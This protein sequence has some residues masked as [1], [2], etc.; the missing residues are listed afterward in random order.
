MRSSFPL[1]VPLA[2]FARFA[3]LGGLATLGP[4]GVVDCGGTSSS[5]SGPDNGSSSGANQSSGGSAAGTGPAPTMASAS[6]PGPYATVTSYSIG[7]PTEADYVN[8]NI[9]YSSSAPTPMPGVVIAPGFTETQTTAVCPLT[10]WAKFLG[11]Y[12]FVVMLIDTASGGAANTITPLPPDR[13][14]ALM[15]AEKNLIAENTRTGSPL[16]GKIDT[17]RMALMGH[18]MGGGGTLIAANA[19]GSS[20][21]ELKAAIGLC[22]WNSATDPYTMDTVPSLMFDGTADVLVSV[23]AG[24]MATGEYS[25]IPT[26]TPKMYSEFT[27]GTHYVAC[28]PQG[29]A[30]TDIVVARQGLSWLEVHVMG[31]ARYAQFLAQDPTNSTFNLDP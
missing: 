19:N 24:G 22:P 4:L 3:T 15:E 5:T 7:V 12:G 10:Q 8:P 11:S 20:H 17:T 23:G 18:S 31:D 16:A 25:S 1:G 14:N 28:T 2:R 21:P 27:G 9:Y 13:A 29:T 6:M 26:S 30:A